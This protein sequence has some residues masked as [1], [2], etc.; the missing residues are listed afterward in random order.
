MTPAKQ[1][2]ISVSSHD[3]AVLDSQKQRF[4]RVTGQK[5]D[6]G[7]FLATITLLGLAA[8]GVYHLV[9]AANRTPQSLDVE[10]DQCHGTF[11]MALPPGSDRAIYT[12]CPRCNTELV[13]YLENQR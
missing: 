11:L 13:V 12:T 1:R 4:D 8:A 9:R 6:W 2:P 3:R 10:C 5:S 7:S